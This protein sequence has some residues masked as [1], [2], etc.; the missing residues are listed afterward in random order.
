MCSAPTPRPPGTP[1]TWGSA[2]AAASSRPPSGSTSTRPPL[3]PAGP[4]R[5]GGPADPATDFPYSVSATDPQVLDIDATT[6]GR[7]VSWYLE[8]SWSCGPQQGLLRIDDHGRPFRTAGMRGAPMYS[9]LP[10]NP[11]VWIPGDGSAPD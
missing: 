4:R 3:G 9:H 5:P 2:A 10:G 1:T 11:S 7:D 8:L 6:V